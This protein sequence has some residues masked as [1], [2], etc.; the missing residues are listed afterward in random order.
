[1]VG[2]GHKADYFSLEKKKKKKLVK[3]KEVETG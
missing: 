3:S 2:V 1:M